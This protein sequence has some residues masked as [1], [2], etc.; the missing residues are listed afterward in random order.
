[1]LHAYAGYNFET[2]TCEIGNIQTHRLLGRLVFCSLHMF[3][4]EFCFR[5]TLGMRLANLN[6]EA[7]QWHLAIGISTVQQGSMHS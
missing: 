4:S 2:R 6:R 1:M 7:Q 5:Y 3:F